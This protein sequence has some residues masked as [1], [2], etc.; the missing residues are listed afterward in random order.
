MRTVER[1][2]IHRPRIRREVDADAAEELFKGGYPR[3]AGWVR[4]LVN[5]DDTAHEIASEA[6]VRLLTRWATVDRPQSYLYIIATN[7]IR[8]HWRKIERERR[9]PM[10]RRMLGN[11]RRT[12][13]GVSGRPGPGG[14]PR[15]GAGRRC[16]SGR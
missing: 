5:D 12:R 11:P 8:D 14:F 4:R 2:A 6:F 3:L 9:V 13:P 16:R 15:G 1:I 7:L 10:W